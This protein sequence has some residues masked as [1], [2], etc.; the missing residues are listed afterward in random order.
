MKIIEF[1]M[2]DSIHKTLSDVMAQVIQ[3]MIIMD[4]AEKNCYGVT[5][6][7][8]YTIDILYQHDQLTMKELSQKLGLAISTLTR[9]VNVLVR[10]EIVY[11][12]QSDQDRRKVL[13]GLTEK[14]KKLA[15]KIQKCSCQF[16]AKVFD[17]IPADNYHQLK[18]SLNIL[19]NALNG[20]EKSCCSKNDLLTDRGEVTR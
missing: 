1:L 4:R 2:D 10:D 15:E 9:I 5:L 19:L 14:G 12:A 6:S 8:S 7:Q 3:K 17:S 11:R 20:M 18:Q 16:W 13:I